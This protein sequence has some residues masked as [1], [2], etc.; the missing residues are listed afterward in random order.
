M[1]F[2]TWLL[3]LFKKQIIP[4]KVSTDISKSIF[5]PTV[6]NIEKFRGIL[7]QSSFITPVFKLKKNGVNH[8]KIGNASYSKYYRIN[9][10]DYFEFYDCIELIQN[11]LYPPLSDY[12]VLTS[13]QK[14]NL[15]KQFKLKI[16]FEF[17]LDSYLFKVTFH[18]FT[19]SSF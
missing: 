18:S 2:F 12:D 4:L 15:E 8:I 7:E 13:S 5:D 17:K 6:T 10:S 9:N 19:S 3:T 14:Q 1:Y 11:L 16:D